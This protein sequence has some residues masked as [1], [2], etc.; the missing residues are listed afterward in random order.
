MRL[1]VQL[2]L[3]SILDLYT[4]TTIAGIIAHYTVGERWWG[5]ALW[6][7]LQPLMLIFAPL[8][9]LIGLAVRW[10]RVAAQALACTA[11]FLLWYG[12]L[13]IPKTPALAI[14][15][16]EVAI[17]LLTYNVLANGRPDDRPLALVQESGADIVAL[18]EFRRNPTAAHFRDALQDQYPHYILAPTGLMSRYPITEQTRW[19]VDG[20]PGFLRARLDVEGNP[21][22]VYVVHPA[23]PAVGIPY[24]TTQRD[25]G[26]QQVLDRARQETEPVILIGDFNMS[27]ASALYKTIHAGYVDAHRE[28]GRGFGNTFP[29]FGAIFPNLWFLPPIVRLDYVFYSPDRI[30]SIEARVLQET[31]GSDHHPLLVQLALKR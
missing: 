16:D 28:V 8:V 12:P 20:R 21:L 5:V 31:G 10:Y 14:A 1:R 29:H 22:V 7:S 27:D 26:L 18:Q 13:F 23:P 25:K 15:P 17:T 2:L 9:L 24:S 19:R 11:V 3:K 6:N 4:L 30:R